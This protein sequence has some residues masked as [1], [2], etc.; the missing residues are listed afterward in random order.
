[1][2][3]EKRLATMNAGKSWRNPDPEPWSPVWEEVKLSKRKM[4]VKMIGIMRIELSSRLRVIPFRSFF[5]IADSAL[6]SPSL[7]REL[8][9]GAYSEVVTLTANAAGDQ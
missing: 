8:E 2:I 7:R 5:T 6:V 9:R 4:A 1:M 3:R